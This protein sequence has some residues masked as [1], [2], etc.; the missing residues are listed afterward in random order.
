MTGTP[1]VGWPLLYVGTDGRLRGQFR[2]A[3]IAPI[4]SAGT[5]NDNRWH[6]VVLSAMGS[7]QT[8][9]LDGVRVGTLTGTIDH[10]ALTFNQVGAGYAGTP[11]SWPGWGTT[12]R[13]FFAGTIDEVA[14]YNHPL[15]AA[16]VGTPPCAP[17][18]RPTS[19]PGS[20]C[21][22]A[23]SPPPPATT[24]RRTGCASTPTATAA[25]GSSA[26]PRS[27]AATTTCAAASRCSTR[28]R[29]PYL[30]EYDALA[31]RLLRTG[32]PLG[33]GTRQEDLPGFPAPSPSPTQTCPS[34]DPTDPSFCTRAAGQRR[35]D[36]RL[37]ARRRHG[38]P[39][40]SS[41]DAAGLPAQVTNENG[42]HR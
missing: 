24:S 36:L 39:R 5:V 1:A 30:Y 21:P 37:P 31:G 4:T 23:R 16:A 41:Y 15:G 14:V 26:P 11:A 32:T 17:P 38:H 33:I 28:P 6:H 2:T 42:R 22:A 20:R 40:R 19:S 18:R 27:P 3:S 34:P 25:P 29:R 10:A 9:Y 8:L 12:A 13:R 7:T 35:P